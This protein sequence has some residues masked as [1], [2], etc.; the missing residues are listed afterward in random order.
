MTAT[1]KKEGERK[2]DRAIDMTFPASD[3]VATG[4]ATSTEPPKR[5]AGRKPPLIDKEDI[6]RARRGSGHTQY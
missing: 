4:G 3:P 6:E 5:P 2:V 1:T